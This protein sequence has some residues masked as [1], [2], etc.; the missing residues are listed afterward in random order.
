MKIAFNKTKV[1]LSFI[2]AHSRLDGEKITSERLVQFR[3]RQAAQTASAEA[4][5]GSG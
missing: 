1:F 4:I 5:P 2:T 3:P